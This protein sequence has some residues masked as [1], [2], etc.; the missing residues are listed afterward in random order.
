MVE[1]GDAVEVVRGV[2]VEDGDVVRVEGVRSIKP[3][4]QEEDPTAQDR[5]LEAQ[6]RNSDARGHGQTDRV[7]ALRSDE[8]AM[9]I[10]RNHRH[11][12]KPTLLCELK[13]GLLDHSL[14]NGVRLFTAYGRPNILHIAPTTLVHHLRS[15]IVEN[16]GRLAR[17]VHD[18][19]H[20][21][22]LHAQFEY[23][24]RPPHRFSVFFLVVVLW[25]VQVRHWL[26][27]VEH[28]HAPFDRRG[29]AFRV[30]QIG[31]EDPEPLRCA[32]QVREEARVFGVPVAV[33]SHGGVHGVALLEEFHDEA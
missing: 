21:A 2:M 19:L 13:S 12:I 20:C 22:G 5:G 31:D 8:G 10:G 11:Q 14:A 18:S 6:A 4:P 24:H 29:K 32:F 26:R 17:S 23:T 1:G 33:R 27:H 15:L 30:V 25:V 28:A 16:H 7:R 9:Y 3:E